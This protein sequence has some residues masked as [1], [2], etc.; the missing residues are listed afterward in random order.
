METIRV[1]L[2]IQGR[3]GR[4]EL[5]ALRDRAINA[6]LIQPDPTLSERLFLGELLLAIEKEVGR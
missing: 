5:A 6:F 4:D 1:R 2:R 3:P